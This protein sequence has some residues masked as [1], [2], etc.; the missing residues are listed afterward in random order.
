VISPPLTGG[1]GSNLV[2]RP[3]PRLEA[4]GRFGRRVVELRGNPAHLEQR[5]G[6]LIGWLIPCGASGGMRLRPLATVVWPDAALAVLSASRCPG[7]RISFAIYP[8]LRHPV[9]S[10]EEILR[11]NKTSCSSQFLVLGTELGLDLSDRFKLLGAGRPERSEPSPPS[12]PS[13]TRPRQHRPPRGTFDTKAA[14]DPAATVLPLLMDS[15][16]QA[17]RWSTRRH[18]D[19]SWPA[20]SSSGTMPGGGCI[21]PTPSAGPCL[22]P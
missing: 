14:A 4:P 15:P 20:L 12:S 7:Q 21:W 19:Q 6:G 16:P 3:A 17:D 13:A 11:K 10:N 2:R 9:R 22:G 18:G 8:T 5:T 1:G